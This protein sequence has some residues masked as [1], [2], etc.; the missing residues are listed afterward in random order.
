[1]NK[2]KTIYAS[3]VAAALSI[4]TTTAVTIGGELSL[5]F[6]NLLKSF[7]GH[8][9]ITK[10]WLSII[11]FAVVFVAVRILSKKENAARTRRAVAMLVWLTVAASLVLAGFYIFEYTSR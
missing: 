11:V 6:K 10:S 2:L 9:W 4:V 3:A 1:M 5:P 7:T 8:H